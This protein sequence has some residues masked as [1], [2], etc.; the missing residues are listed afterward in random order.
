[1]NTETLKTEVLKLNKTTSFQIKAET[2]EIGRC[3]AGGIAANNSANIGRAISLGMA[4]GQDMTLG[5][6]GAQF[7]AVGR[8]LSIQQ[9]GAQIVTV[10][11]DLSIQ[12]G[13][14]VIL[15]ANEVKASNCLVGLVVSNKTTLSDNS[16]AVFTTPQVVLI[17]LLTGAILALFRLFLKRSKG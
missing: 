14:G 4:V 8:D 15:T 11:R 16:R 10:G 6:G 3:V 2:L 12:Q 17:G 1:M 7:L 9:G 13:G 5:S